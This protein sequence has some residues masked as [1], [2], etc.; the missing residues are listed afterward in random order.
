MALVSRILRHRRCE[1]LISFMYESINRFLGHPDAEIQVR[2]DELFG[3][4]EW[5]EIASIGDPDTRKDRLVSLY[6]EQLHKQAGVKY[7]RGFEMLNEGN[8][9]EYFLFYAT[10]DK[11][12]LSKMKQAMW[13]T[14]PGGGQAFS[15]RSQSD[16]L[17]LFKPAPDTGVLRKQLQQRFRGKG[18]VTIEEVS[19]FVLEETAYSEEMHLKRATLS[20]LE[21]EGLLEAQRPLDKRDRRGT[22]PDGTKLKFL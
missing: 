15:D 21:K 8:R 2:F 5:R 9:T 11:L 6:Q 19:D 3:T 4:T 18:W 14:D 13:R 17:V 20:P 12:G 22:Y 10:N 1:C 16:Q 7:V